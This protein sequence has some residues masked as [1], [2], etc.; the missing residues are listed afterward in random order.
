MDAS[1]LLSETLLK[2][3]EILNELLTVVVGQRDALKEG[4]LADLQDLMSDLRHVSV[5]C[6]AIETKRVRTAADL[7]KELGC[8]PIVSVI[9]AALPEED[10]TI[11]MDAARALMKTV[12]KL[13]IEMSILPRLMEEAHTLNEMMINEWRKLGQQSTGLGAMGSF[14]TRI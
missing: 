14:D 1:T 12:S 9:A 6:Q 2:Q 4:R 5:R 3:D 8:E 11:V 7:A 10:S 13:K